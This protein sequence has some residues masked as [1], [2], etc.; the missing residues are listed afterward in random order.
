M[1]ENELS[2][3]FLSALQKIAEEISQLRK[4]LSPEIPTTKTEEQKAEELE[5]LKFKIFDN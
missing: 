4:A 1:K 3:S 5:Q 2:K